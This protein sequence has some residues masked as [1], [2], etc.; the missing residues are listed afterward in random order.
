MNDVPTGVFVHPLGLCESSAVGAG[1]RVWAFAHVMPRAVVG[2]DCN[3]CDHAFIEDGVVIGNG[4]TVKNGVMIFSGVI[5]GD[6]AFLGPGVIF[7]NGMRPR[8]FLKGDDA[9]L[10][11]T[12]IDEGATLGAGTVVVCGHRVAEYAFVGAASVVT[13]DV[14]EYA[15]VK[16]NPAHQDGWVCRCGQRLDRELRCACG[17]RYR[18]G[19]PYGGLRRDETVEATPTN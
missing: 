6:R 4:V 18:T 15:F 16:G 8:A 3:I 10:L 17:E 14:P 11:E 5:V 12:W 2:T 1:T 13:R 9:P 19:A 7:T